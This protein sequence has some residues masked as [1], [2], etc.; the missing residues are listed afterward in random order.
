MDEHVS[1][2]VLRSV[3]EVEQIRGLWTSWQSHPNSDMEG[4][5]ARLRSTPEFLRPYILVLHRNGSPDAMMIGR[6][7]RRRIDLKVGYWS[8]WNPQVRVLSVLY[9]GLL[10]NEDSGNCKVMIREIL[11]SLRRG[12]ADL[13]EFN[14]VKLDSPIYHFATRLPGILNRDH[15][16]KVELHCSMTLPGSVEEIYQRLSGDSRREMRRR[17]RKLFA[18]FSGNVRIECFRE[19]ADL[20]HMMQDMEEVA[21]KTYQRGLGVGFFNNDKM[22]RRLE[23]AALKGSLRAFVM[24]IA[25]RPCAFWIGTLYDETF[26]TGEVGYDAYYKKYALGTMLLMRMFGDL[27]REN[28][29]N[30]DFGYGVEEY[31]RRFG[32]NKWQEG[33]VYI[34]GP[35]FRGFVLKVLETLTDLLDRLVRRTLK[36]ARL[37]PKVKRIWR[38][39]VRSKKG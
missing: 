17:A 21:K 23:S 12:E 7:D 14:Y 35:S 10:G 28:V 4:Y 31:K 19:A 37:L 36:E 6:I 38:N 33:L 8:V 18:D 30:V 15:F 2:Q 24:Y 25:D 26:Y 39:R 20:E 27:C 1:V 22:R 29:K 9:R 13:A 34:F 5:L 32:N 11:N 3:E 16:P